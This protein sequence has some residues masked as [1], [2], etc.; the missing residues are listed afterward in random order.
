MK[1]V[2]RVIQNVEKKLILAGA[3]KRA[4]ARALSALFKPGDRVYRIGRAYL[5]I[6]GESDF[7]LRWLS[8]VKSTF[9]GG[10]TK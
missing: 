10:S 2:L 3:R 6:A 8:F 4:Y 9:D 5:I 7:W 1:R